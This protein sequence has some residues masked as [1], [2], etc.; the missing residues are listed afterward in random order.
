MS[1][2]LGSLKTW[3]KVGSKFYWPKLIDDV[4]HYV[5]KCYLCQHA[6]PA[7]DTKFTTDTSVLPLERFFIDFLGLY[8]Y[9]G[10]KSRYFGGNG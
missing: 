6:K 3:K 7:Q 9:Y 1:G 5:R 10:R 8:Y 4:S 2:H